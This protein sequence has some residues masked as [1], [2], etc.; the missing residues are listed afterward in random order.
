[1]MRAK[2]KA[3]SLIMMTPTVLA[4]GAGTGVALALLEFWHYQDFPEPTPLASYGVVFSLLFGQLWAMRTYRRLHGDMMRFRHAWSVGVGV[5]IYASMLSALMVFAFLQ[6]LSPSI[7]EAQHAQV[8]QAL[9]NQPKLRHLHFRKL[10]YWLADTLLQPVFQ[11]GVVFL[12]Q[13]TLASLVATVL[14]VL[15]RK[16]KEEDD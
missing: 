8:M 16:N 13:I 5:G 12:Y 14:S 4:Y 10:A 2:L 15:V 11:A 3:H 1:M 9:E 6:W 7:M